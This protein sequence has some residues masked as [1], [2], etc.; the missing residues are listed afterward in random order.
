[1]SQWSQ[2][3]DAY[4]AANK[5]TKRELA[6]Q[7]GISIGT[8]EKWWGPREPSEE[9]ANKIRKLLNEGDSA[10][11]QGEQPQEKSVVISFFRTR[12]PFCKHTIE[13]FQHC[14]H[15]GQHFVWANVPVTK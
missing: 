3:L 5:I 9:N 6:Q 15:C 4:L 7:L 10:P 2:K 14:T 13:R 11:S 8:L 1:M 12:C